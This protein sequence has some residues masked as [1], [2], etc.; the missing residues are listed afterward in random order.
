[1]VIA[2]V[3]IDRKDL[4]L[5]YSVQYSITA[6]TGSVILTSARVALLPPPFAR[7]ERGG[8]AINICWFS[9]FL[10]FW[11]LLARPFATRAVATQVKP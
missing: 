8:V 2:T 9:G 7:P 6:L 5:A 3:P 1:M 10:V 4:R 11:S